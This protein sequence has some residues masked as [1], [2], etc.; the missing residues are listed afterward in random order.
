MIYYNPLFKG[1]KYT[2]GV[3]AMANKN[4]AYWLIDAISAAQIKSNVKREPFQVWVLTVNQ[5]KGSA[6]LTMDDGNGRTPVYMEKIPYTDFPLPTIKIW[7]DDNVMLL[8]E[9]Y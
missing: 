1:I 5:I 3:K 9:E 6:I 8:P 2:E 4:H 7:V